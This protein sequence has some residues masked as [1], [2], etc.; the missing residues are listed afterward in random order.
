M[1]AYSFSTRLTLLVVLFASAAMP[2]AHA[3]TALGEKPTTGTDHLSVGG[4]VPKPFTLSLDQLRALP[5]VTIEVMNEHEHK[6]EAYE[7]IPLVDLLKRAGAPQGEQI[8][9]ALMTTYVIAEGSDGYRALFSLAELDAAFQDS[10]VIVADRMGG[11]PMSGDIGPLRLIV[12]HDKR[13]ARWV[14]M[15]QSIIVGTASK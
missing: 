15:L 3:Q 8:R 12:P 1:R 9:G 2:F 13:P 4:D 7:G 14:R 10:G 11:A 6:Q 5:H